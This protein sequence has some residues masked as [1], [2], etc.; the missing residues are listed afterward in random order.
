[1][2]ITLF[3]IRFKRQNDCAIDMRFFFSFFSIS[4][5]ENR[6]ELIHMRGVVV[7]HV[8]FHIEF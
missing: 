2:Q 4:L 5:N 6:V 8:Q 1:M 7:V 3:R